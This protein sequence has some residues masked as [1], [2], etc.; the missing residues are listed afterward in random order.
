MKYLSV[1][2][3][4]LT[5]F[6][7][8]LAATDTPVL[9]ITPWRAK[10][11]AANPCVQPDDILLI[12]AMDGSETVVGY[13][14][15]LPT[16]FSGV[17]KE[18][19]FWNS[20]WWVAEHAGAAVAMTLFSMFLKCTD[21]RVAFSD[22]TD[23]TSRIISGMGGFVVDR[24]EGLL[25]RIRSAY[26][27]RIMHAGRRV[28]AMKLLAVTGMIRLADLLINALSAGPVMKIPEGDRGRCRVT[29]YEAMEERHAGFIRAH[30]GR[31]FSVPGER[32]FGWWSSEPWLVQPGRESVRIARRYYFSALAER[33]ELRVLE[34]GF[35]GELEGVAIVSYRDGVV[36]P[37]YIFHTPGAGSQ[38]YAALMENV[39]ADKGVHTI[40][41]F[42]PGL[43]AYIKEGHLVSGKIEEKSRYTG[44]SKALAGSSGA[45][46]EFQDGDGD[47]I[48]T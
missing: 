47:Y 21:R 3:S 2:A 25:L 41:T 18:R 35:E 26:H 22:M 44:Y 33:N 43:T 9:P 6:A 45:V 17:L 34:F 16:C 39:V 40:I 29:A 7:E 14:G 11:Q 37:H 24:R 28:P 1:K 4:E 36:K 15:V 8:Q 27:Q 48:F 10:S 19:I 42:H 46:F 23:R 20:C 12:V 13:I 31:G 30:R 32:E 38:V 5:G